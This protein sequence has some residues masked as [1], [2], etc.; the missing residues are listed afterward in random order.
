MTWCL[1]LQHVEEPVAPPVKRSLVG[2]DFVIRATFGFDRQAIEIVILGHSATI[3]PNGV[4]ILWGNRFCTKEGMAMMALIVPDTQKP[5]Y[6][7]MPAQDT[8]DLDQK[9]ARTQSMRRL[10]EISIKIHRLVGIAPLKGTNQT[11]NAAIGVIRER[12]GQRIGAEV[13]DEQ[14]QRQPAFPDEPLRLVQNDPQS[15]MDIRKIDQDQTLVYRKR[16]G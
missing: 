9:V 2:F 12:E 15:R 10:G 8:A 5:A 6:L 14:V 11:V 3:L 13:I 7:P 1:A 16:K 4:V